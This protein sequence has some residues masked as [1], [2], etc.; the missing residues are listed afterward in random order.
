[1]TNVAVRKDVRS[2]DSNIKVD[3][4]HCSH[5]RKG[6]FNKKHLNLRIK[7]RRNTSIWPVAYQ[8]RDT[9]NYDFSGCKAGPPDTQG[10]TKGL[11]QGLRNTYISFLYELY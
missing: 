7:M 11:S 10:K 8:G 1:M 5:S 9:H 2:T 6:I 3:A 4:Q